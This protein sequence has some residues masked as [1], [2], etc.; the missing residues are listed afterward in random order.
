MSKNY[1]ELGFSEYQTHKWIVFDGD[2]DTLWIESMCVACAIV[3]LRRR[4]HVLRF[5]NTGTR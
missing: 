5:L 2:I 4:Y 1:K 3:C